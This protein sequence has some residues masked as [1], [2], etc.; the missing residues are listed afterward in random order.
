M[1]AHTNSCE[2]PLSYVN[3]SIISKL[4]GFLMSLAVNNFGGEGEHK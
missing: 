3:V 4:T 2:Q 1:H